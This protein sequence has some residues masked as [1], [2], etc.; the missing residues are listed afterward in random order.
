MATATAMLSDKLCPISQW[1]A[2]IIDFCFHG[3]ADQLGGSG[4]SYELVQVASIC[5]PF[6]GYDLLKVQGRS[7]RDQAKQREPMWSLWLLWCTLYSHF[8][9][10]RL[11]K[12]TRS[13]PKSLLWRST[14]FFQWIMTEI[15]KE[16]KSWSI[17]TVYY[18]E[19]IRG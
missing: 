12:I 9:F 15:G 5:Y 11:R 3:S 6:H 14:I 13:T 7:A 17:S 18:R 4:S 19:V 1:F 8:T 2:T 10:H 16:G